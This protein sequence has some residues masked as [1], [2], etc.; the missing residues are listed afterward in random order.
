MPPADDAAPANDWLDEAALTAEDVDEEALV[1]A[2]AEDEL[3]DMTNDELAQLEA[4]LVLGEDSGNPDDEE[5][6]Q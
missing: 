3:G 1:V 6:V 5:H 2:M 4:G